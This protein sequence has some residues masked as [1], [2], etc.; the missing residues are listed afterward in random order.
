MVFL[1]GIMDKSF[2]G[3]GKMGLKAV[4]EFGNHLK[5]TAMKDNGCKI[6]N[7]AKVFLNTEPV[8]IKDHLRIF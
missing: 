7:M 1:D 5:V 2:K 3:S 4:M 8:F 6:D